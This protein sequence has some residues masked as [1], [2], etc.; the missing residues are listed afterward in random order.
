M[1]EQRQR[2]Q[3]HRLPAHWPKADDESRSSVAV[4]T[5]T[6]LLGIWLR[7]GPLCNVHRVLVVRWPLRRPVTRIVLMLSHSGSEFLV[8]LGKMN[9]LERG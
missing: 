8:R 3:R 1:A 6:A 4:E 7:S 9:F 2:A 5:A